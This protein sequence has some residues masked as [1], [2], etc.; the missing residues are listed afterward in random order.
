MKIL[1]AV[2]H[3]AASEAA[4]SAV[5]LRPWPSGTTVEVLGVVEPP[6]DLDVSQILEEINRRTGELVDRAAEQLRSCGL[7]ATPLVL[8]GDPKDVIVNRAGE[9]KA[10]FAVVG[11]H[12]AS[13]LTRFL[14]GSVAGAVVRFAP[15]SV[16]VVRG[17]AAQRALKIL[18]ATDGSDSS[19][20]AARSIAARPWPHGTEVR[21]LS[22]VE[23][24]LSTFQAMLEPPFADTA[25]MEA[26]R[27]QAM[28]QSQDAIR[29]AEE[30]VT[31]AG[32]KASEDIS[33]L[34]ESPK[35]IILD[36]ARQ[37]GA[38]LIVVGSHGRRGINRF[39]LGGASQA[40]AMHAECSVEVI[41]GSDPLE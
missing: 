2:D 31:G 15:C 29:T 7:N 23:M 33:V 21:I 32:L 4:V 22:A 35:Q 18:L 13:G 16:E 14:L 5:A 36:E 8:P 38:D 1:L 40:V 25:A 9:I 24:A 41:R 30:I 12:G 37:W 11:S 20:R 27:E 34:L 19:V 39:L 28:K 6:E 10:D 17:L 26:L 3:S